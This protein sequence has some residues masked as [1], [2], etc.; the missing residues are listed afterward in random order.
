MSTK[1]P[2]LFLRVA[3]GGNDKDYAYDFDYGNGNGTAREKLEVEIFVH[4]INLKQ[5]V[6]NGLFISKICG[7]LKQWM[8]KWILVSKI[9]S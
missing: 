5:E 1:V 4:K 6:E 9:Y 3:W 8:G 2:P 7:F